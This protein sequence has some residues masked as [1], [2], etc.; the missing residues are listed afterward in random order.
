MG[1][2]EQKTCVDYGRLPAYLLRDVEQQFKAN[3]ESD[4]E[5]IQEHA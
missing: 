5:N 2:E 4:N 3:A 1:V